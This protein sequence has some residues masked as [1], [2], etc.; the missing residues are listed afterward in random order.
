MKMPVPFQ[1]FHLLNCMVV[2]NLMLW[3]YG[4]GASTSIFG[5]LVYFFATLIF[6]GMLEVATQ[7]ADPFGDADNDYPLWQWLSEA[8]AL[9][10]CH[11]FVDCQHPVDDFEFVY[12]QLDF[13]E[14]L[15]ADLSVAN[16]YDQ[17][18]S[19]G[20]DPER[21]PLTAEA[22]SQRFFRFEPCCASTERPSREDLGIQSTLARQPKTG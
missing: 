16:R 1:H 9:R 14:R 5:P 20:V 8:Q 15:C 21:V 18:M 10:A 12:A 17:Y 19:L 6:M 2:I 4:M 13:E 3:S 7:L 11:F 22:Q